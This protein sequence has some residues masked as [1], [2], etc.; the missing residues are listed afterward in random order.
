MKNNVDVI[1]IQVESNAEKVASLCQIVQKYF[2]SEEKVLIFVSS[3]QAANYVD[4]LLWK[5]PEESFL[6]HQVAESKTQERV[7]ITTQSINVNEA[8]ILLNLSGVLCP[9]YSQFQK[10]YEL[11]DKTDKE[12]LQLSKKRYEAYQAMKITPKVKGANEVYF[13]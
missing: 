5:Y 1:F 12:K 9:I 13:L 4:Q 3:S 6:P 2:S 7:A 8:S 10:V 11:M